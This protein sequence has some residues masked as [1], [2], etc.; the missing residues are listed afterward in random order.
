MWKWLP[1][2]KLALLF[3]LIFPLQAAAESGC[4]ACHTSEATLKG[5]FAPP[6]AIASE[7]EG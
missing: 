7:G 1:A 3:M 6:K 4:I 2:T 5:L